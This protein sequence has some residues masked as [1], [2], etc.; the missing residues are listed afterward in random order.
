MS[1]ERLTKVSAGKTNWDF[2]NILSNFQVKSVIYKLWLTRFLN[3][4]NIAVTINSFSFQVLSE[5]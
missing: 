1:R 2:N 4:L 3:I 5:E